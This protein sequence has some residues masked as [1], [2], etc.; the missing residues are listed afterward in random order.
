MWKE[1]IK[2]VKIS[3]RYVVQNVEIFRAEGAE[4]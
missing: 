1:L 2:V 3:V 4:K